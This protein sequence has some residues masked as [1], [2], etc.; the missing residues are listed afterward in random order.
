MGFKKEKDTDYS[1]LFR[2][3][4]EFRHK[5]V[6]KI[7]PKADPKGKAR[8]SSLTIPGTSASQPTQGRQTLNSLRAGLP[9]VSFSSNSRGLAQEPLV[10][11]TELR[12][13]ASRTQ[14]AVR[15]ASLTAESSPVT[16]SS[17]LS[18]LFPTIPET[19]STPAAGGSS[20]G[21][22]NALPVVASTSR[23]MP[24]PGERNAPTF[25][26]E[27]P[28]EL[29][30]F[31]DRIEDWFAE[32]GIATDDEK[33]KRIVK[34]LDADSEIQWKAFSKF[35]NGTFEEYKAQVMASYPKAEDVMKGSMTA[36]NRKVRQIGPIEVDERDVLLNL[37]RIMAA[38]VKKLKRI[39]PPIHT[40]RELVE[41]FLSR[42]TPDFATRIAHKLSVHRLVHA[43][44]AGQNA[45]AVRNPEDMY[46]IE[47]VME[48]AKQTAMESANPFG[49]FLWTTGPSGSDTSVKLEQ[50][51][52]RL[53]DTIHIQAQHSKQVDQRLASLQT[54]MSQP[55][56]VQGTGF[57]GQSSYNRGYAPATNHVQPGFSN[58]CFYCRGNDGHRI[59]DCADALKHLDLGWIK[60]ID[61]QLRLKDGSK[62]PREGNKSMKEV[63]ETLNKSQPGIIPMSKIQDK[64]SLYQEAAMAS[65][66]QGQSTEDPDMRTLVEAVQKLGTDRVLKLLTTQR[67][68]LDDV[69]EGEWSQN[70]D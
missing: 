55:R 33:K 66:M 1:Y 38:E 9:A 60:K 16:P 7:P 11:R 25:D 50:A 63:V 19:M 8:A 2:F 39:T 47:E 3:S 65:Y 56:P 13:S 67:P 21:Q 46:D 36:L 6:H 35:E 27:K 53:T 4:T 61:G 64:S 59:P 54:F 62:I 31:F 51:V 57:A 52:A 14:A 28:E 69:E 41:L 68:I 18:N 58:D 17:H 30:R 34:Y 32:D 15:R 43:G 45:A 5:L 37:V 24:K 26:P 29:G 44:G 70:F 23:K 42:L 10:Q 22:T 48:M 12:V 40:N 49:K 20:S